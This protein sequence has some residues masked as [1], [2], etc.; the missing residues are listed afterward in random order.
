MSGLI[1]GTGERSEGR[2]GWVAQRGEMGGRGARG[3]LTEEEGVSGDELLIL[4]FSRS[5]FDMKSLLA[6]SAGAFLAFFYLSKRKNNVVKESPPHPSWQAGENQPIPYPGKHVLLLP[7]QMKSCYP[8]I[9]SAYV[10]RPIALVSSK[11]AAG[12]V[13]V[14]PYSYTGAISHDPPALVVSC[15]RKAG[16]A[17]K[18]TLSNVLETKEFVVNIMSEWYAESANHT[19]GN[20]PP[21]VNEMDVAGL[22]P[23]PSEMISPPRVAESAINFECRLIHHYDMKNAQGK[24]TATVVIGEIVAFHVHEAVLE[25]NGAGEG[26]PTVN[27]DALKPLVRDC[28]RWSTPAEKFAQSRLG[29]CTYGRTTAVFDLPRLDRASDCIF[30]EQL[31]KENFFRLSISNHHGRHLVESDLRKT[32]REFAS[33]E[34]SHFSPPESWQQR[35]REP[36]LRQPWATFA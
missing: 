19:C 27:F 23:L 2:R 3:K 21:E 35:E 16:E 9:I 8:L 13:N 5:M 15:A 31:K 32:I 30:H 17:M 25:M 29:G 24:I 14:A 12:Y 6:A 20:F 26:K 10:P 1:N 28:V 34:L 33:S 4:R 22:T 36:S 11:S 18:D 7:S